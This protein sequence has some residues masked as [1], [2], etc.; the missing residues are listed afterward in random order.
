MY[1]LCDKHMEI[2]LAYMQKEKDE[3]AE[4]NKLPTTK[5]FIDTAKEAKQDGLDLKNNW[6][7]E[8]YNGPTDNCSGCPALDCD[9]CPLNGPL[10]GDEDI[11]ETMANEQ[12]N[13]EC[14]MCHRPDCWG[15]CEEIWKEDQAALNGVKEKDLEDFPA[16]SAPL[17]NA[18]KEMIE[19]LI[20]D[21]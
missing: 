4:E 15:E 11:Y 13:H 19:D 14:N 2:E 21:L 5:E 6:G 16:K 3:E 1:N 7:L 17:N 10:P 8:E 18:E 20:K 9:T 12:D